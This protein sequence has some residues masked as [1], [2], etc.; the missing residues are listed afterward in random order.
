MY[1]IDEDIKTGKFSRVYLL[2]GEEAY[3]RLQY[4]DKLK[5][6]LCRPGDALNTVS[7]TGKDVPVGEVIDFANT[8][9]FMA[10]KRV[11]FLEDTT[12]F[13]G[14]NDELSDF[15]KEVPEASCLIFLQ[16]KADKR[17][18]LYKAVQ[19]YGRVVSFERPNEE[20]LKKWVLNRAGNAG[21]SIRRSALEQFMLTVN[22]DMQT[23][24]ME[25]EKLISYCLDKKEISAE[26]VLAINSIRVEDKVFDMIENIVLKKRQEALARYYDLVTLKEPPMK[27][28]VLIGKQYAQILSVKV[29]K[30][31]GMSQDEI[32]GKMGIHPYA[33][34]KCLAN[35][36]KYSIKELEDIMDECADYESRVKQGRINDVMSVELL[37]AELTAAGPRRTD[38]DA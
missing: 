19:K 21:L 31:E 4:R 24:S 38:T 7:Y 18:K 2:T 26:D 16:E 22:A 3:L 30:K 15:I 10:D 27:I 37:I 5:K 23:M 1:S 20:T 13:E 34:K 6:A 14:G 25:L 9:P 36:G 28:L 17:V 8:M 33:V 11:V 32:A 12:L 35:G 29:L